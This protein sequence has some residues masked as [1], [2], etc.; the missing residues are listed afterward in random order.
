MSHDY[1]KRIVPAAAAAAA[2]VAAAP[3]FLALRLLCPVVLEGGR[4][5]RHPSPPLCHLHDVAHDVGLRAAQRLSP[6][7]LRDL[8]GHVRADEKP[9]LFG[10]HAVELLESI[11]SRPLAALGWS[12][13]IRP[14]Q[15]LPSVC[16]RGV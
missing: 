16:P 15:F 2:A 10:A 3:S 5:S 14:Q 8:A 6:E 13:R 4:S 12:G 7:R 11:S 1:Y 9:Q